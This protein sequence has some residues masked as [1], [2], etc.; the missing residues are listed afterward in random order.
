MPRVADEAYF[1]YRPG[2]SESWRS[3]AVCAPI[4][5]HFWWARGTETRAAR[6]VGKR[7]CN[8]ICPVKDE[9]LTYAIT[10]GITHGTWGGLDE[11]QR[12]ALR[13]TN[14]PRLVARHVT[15]YTEQATRRTENL[16]VTVIAKVRF[17]P[18]LGVGEMGDVEDDVA[19]AAIRNGY[20]ELVGSVENYDDWMYQGAE[21]Q[22]ARK[23]AKPKAP[24]GS[25]KQVAS[26]ATDGGQ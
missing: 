17:A 18:N 4:R 6:S 12:R 5:D 7:I 13:R 3:Q 10:A 25:K 26:T 21:L 23:T 19:R 1:N 16:M 9:C 15:T 24:R 20:A 22:L 11:R 14:D 2:H 8:E